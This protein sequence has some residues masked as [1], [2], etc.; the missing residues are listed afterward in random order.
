MLVVESFETCTGTNIVG[1]IRT[2]LRFFEHCSQILTTANHHVLLNLRIVL[3]VRM[4]II[5]NASNL[6]NVSTRLFDV[7]VLN[8][9]KKEKMKK[10]V[11]KNI[12][13]N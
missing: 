11:S 7:M 2:N 6:T 3:L 1:F 4:K 5:T 12:R 10:I 9:A 8:N 13:K